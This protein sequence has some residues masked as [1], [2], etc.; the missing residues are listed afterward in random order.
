MF[1]LQKFTRSNLV[2]VSRL[3]LEELVHRDIGTE[4][5]NDDTEEEY[6]TARDGKFLP[7][8]H[9]DQFRLVKRPGIEASA[10]ET[11]CQQSRNYTHQHSPLDERLTDEAPG[12]THQL[13]G[14]DGESAGIDAQSHRIVDKRER[15]KGK[16]G[17]YDKE[18]DAYLGERIVHLFYR[19]RADNLLLSRAN[20]FSAPWLSTSGNHCW[21]NPPVS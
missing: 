8:E 19:G 18:T 17:G 6:R 14:M 2:Q 21:H 7:A 15:D 10:E 5:R 9:I 1:I 13:H 16:Q 3:H 4:S 11:V 20:S 12:C